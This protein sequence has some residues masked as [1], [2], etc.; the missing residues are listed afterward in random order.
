MLIGVLGNAE[1]WY[2]HELQ[3]AGGELGHEVVRLEFPRIVASCGFVLG[4]ELCD[5][6]N[7]TPQ[8]RVFENA[9][10]C[11][12]RLNNF[13]LQIAS[14]DRDLTTFDAVIIRTMPPARCN[15]CKYQLSALPSTPMST[16]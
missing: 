2:L 12:V 5:S 8:A 4:A 13:R 10:A 15:S 1:S 11:G 6:F 7:R 16:K 3:R 14:G 9:R